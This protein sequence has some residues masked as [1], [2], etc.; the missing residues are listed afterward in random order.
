MLDTLCKGQQKIGDEYRRALSLLSLRKIK[1]K[2]SDADRAERQDCCAGH[3]FEQGVQAFEGDADFEQSMNVALAHPRRLSTAYLIL[4]RLKR[5]SMTYRK[6][7]TRA[8]DLLGLAILAVDP[9]PAP[10]IVVNSLQL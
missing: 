3:Q 6:C 9:R 10:G 4:A 8:I 1:E 7:P 5:T 2:I